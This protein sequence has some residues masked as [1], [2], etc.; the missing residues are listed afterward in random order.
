MIGF[1]VGAA[2]TIEQPPA[3]RLSS[4]IPEF[5][6]AGLFAL[7]GLRSLRKWMRLEFPATSTTEQIVYALNVTSRVG[8]WF[9]LAGF[10]VGFAL[11]DDPQSFGWYVFVV[12]G[13]AS[14]QLLSTFYLGRDADARVDSRADDVPPLPLFADHGGSVMGDE[15][16]SF[17]QD[18]RPLFREKDRL[19]MEWAFDLWRQEDVKQNAPQ[20]LERLQGGDMPCDGAWPA[21]R[22]ETFRRWVDGGMAP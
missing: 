21:E 18:I 19:R 16:V 1:L 5:V 2:R 7:M 20:I 14:V 22:I 8:M 4:Y 10:F 6:I 13:L 12:L 9:A 15:V 11:V 17:E 3:P